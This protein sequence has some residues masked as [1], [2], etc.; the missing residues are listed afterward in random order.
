MLHE[1][2][3]EHPPLRVLNV[4]EYPLAGFPRAASMIRCAVL[5]RLESALPSIRAPTLLLR[6]ERDRLSTSAWA[7]QLAALPRDARL[8]VLPGLGH[9]VFYSQPETVAAAAT[10]FLLGA[11]PSAR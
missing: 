11:R 1:R 9:D 10:P 6:G 3:G 8:I 2:L 4:C 7:G 5:E